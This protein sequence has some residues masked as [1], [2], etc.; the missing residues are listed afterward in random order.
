M[1]SIRK[2][3]YKTKPPTFQV[4]IRR[5]GSSPIAKSFLTRED[6]I[7]W[8]RKTER[9]LD[10]GS[11]NNYQASAKVTM[12]DLFKRYIIEKKHKRK[13]QWRNE[14]YRKDQIITDPISDKTLLS[15]STKDLADYRDRR[16]AVVKSATFNKD[17]NFISVVVSTAL[18]DW[19]YKLP[20]N[21]CSF[22]KREQE[23]KPR[24]RILEDWEERKLLHGCSL[25]PNTYLT[26]CVEFSLETAIRQ[27]EMLNIHYDD[28][29]F[30]NSLLHI[31]ISKNG[32]PRKIPLSPKAVRILRE[33]P[34]RLDRKV[35]PI[36]RDALKNLFQRALKKSNIQEFRCHDLRHTAITS[37]LQDR[38]LTIP[39]VQLMSGI[40]NPKILLNV[41]NKTDPRKVVARLS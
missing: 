14:E 10:Q 22:F 9:E 28:I 1:A 19:G 21:P 41:Y 31:P 2:R 16:L 27:G 40:R 3:K 24:D 4:Q 8:A 20:N 39:E 30:E 13:R 32:Y 33:L 29:D 26:K 12:G 17:F 34:R 11:F 25:I 36:T 38:G 15:L 7:K 37:M 18:Q 5:V 6:A 35:F 23:A